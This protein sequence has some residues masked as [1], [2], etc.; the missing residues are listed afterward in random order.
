[1]VDIVGNNINELEVIRGTVKLIEQSLE[2][3]FSR[4]LATQPDNVRFMVGLHCTV[5]IGIIR[6][7]VGSKHFGHG[8]K[9]KG[10]IGIICISNHYDATAYMV[11][12]V[13][14]IMVGM[15]GISIG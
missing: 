15:I 5:C 10:S 14:M 12:M 8:V 9:Q 13:G 4:W 7:C 6:L 1:M 2:L 11:G 3:Y